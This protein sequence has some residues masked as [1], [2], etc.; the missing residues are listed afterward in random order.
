MDDLVDVRRW[1]EETFG[2]ADLGDRRRTRRLVHSAA[3]IAA[4]PQQAFTQVFDWNDLRGFY[5]LCD[6]PEAT[7]PA[8]MGPHWEQTRR[9][10]G[11]RP[12]VLILHDTTEL[13][14]TSHRRLRGAGQIGNGYGRGFL[15]HNSL[16]VTPEPREVLGLAHQQLVVRRPAPARETAY[17]RKRRRRESELWAAGFRGTGR[18]DPGHCWVDVADRGGD[19]Y[20]SMRASLGMGHQFL[21][22]ANQNR[23]VFVTP[24][25]DRPE[26]VLDYARSLPSRGGDVVDIRGRGGRAARAAAVSLAAAPV[27]LP[28]PA[29]TPRRRSQPVLA[30][31]VVRVWEPR[32]PAGVTEP[33]DWVLLCSL[34]TATVGQI[35]ERRDW[36]C[37]RWMVEVFHDIEKNGCAEEGRRLETAG[38]LEACLAV[39]SVVAVRV[40]QLRCALEARPDAPADRAGTAAEVELIR[41]LF[42]HA[43]RTLSVREFVRGV[44]R[45]GGFLGR[46]GDGE[47]G[48]RALWRGYQR[49]QDMILGLHLHDPP[50]DD[51]G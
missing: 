13:D 42:G 50:V 45:L 23:L 32:P 4:R 31:W 38:R 30:A 37:C 26:Y 10:M 43:G 12:L 39:L 3:R 11:R 8:V 25:H 40:Y 20:E 49:L 16:A 21:V 15:Q 1:A 24:A 28:A 2:T 48:V 27:W 44:A 51:S 47:P 34:P 18:P 6:Q 29:G 22:R 46:A 41:R 14:F 35:R 17:Q 36:Y 33:L 9:A 7:L 5:R 19:D